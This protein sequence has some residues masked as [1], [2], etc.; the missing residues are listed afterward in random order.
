MMG[1]PTSSGARMP[2]A[3][4]SPIAMTGPPNGFGVGARRMCPRRGRTEKIPSGNTPPCPTHGGVN[5]VVGQGS[6]L[7]FAPLGLLQIVLATRPECRRI[8]PSEPR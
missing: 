5:Y 3:L 6:T 4:N 1:G 2:D 8:G 7:A